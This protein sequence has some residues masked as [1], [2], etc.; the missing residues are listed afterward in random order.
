M[1]QKLLPIKTKKEKP[2]GEVSR[3]AELLLQAGFIHKQMAGVYNLLPFGNRVINR[4]ANVIR[5][6]LEPLGAHELELASLQPKE[7]WE[8]TG[9]WDDNVINIWFKTELRSGGEV[10]LATTHEEPLTALLTEH[11]SSYRDLPASFYQFQTKFR[12]ELRAKSGI[13]RG[14]EFLMKDLYSFS[15]TQEEH[16]AFYE[17]AKEAYKTIFEAV[18]IGEQTLLTFASG[19]SF[20][21]FSHEFQAL[22]DAGED[23]IFVH[24]EK[25]VA[26]NKEVLTD[27]VCAELGVSH[28]E[29]TEHQAIEVGN[30]FTLGTKFSEPLG[31]SYRDK[32][33]NMQPVIMGSYGIGLGRLMGTVV[34]LN[35]DEKGIVWPKSIA[36]FDMH[37][38]V[39]AEGE[40]GDVYTEAE[41]L[42]THLEGV[43]IAVLYDDRDVSAGEKFADSD[44]VGIP[45]RVVVSQRTHKEGKYEVKDRKTGEVTFMTQDELI[46]VLS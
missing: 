12:N 14:R 1:R 23:T 26:I 22:T 29:L 11:I 30:I 38:L 36:P 45:L 41:K 44:L 34:E 9:R 32:D 28:N 15:R 42:Y 27:E 3:N 21:K 6:A 10:G 16:E 46:S 43:G 35:H 31:L 37:V 13:L 4:I 8:K 5:D 2:G 39:L 40:E 19:G 17:R 33:G 18:G 24:E 20:A 7:L 25:Q